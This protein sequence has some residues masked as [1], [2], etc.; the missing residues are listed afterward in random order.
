M[1]KKTKIKNKSLKPIDID[2]H[3]KYR[4]PGCGIDHWASFKEASTRHFIIVCDCSEVFSVKRI[5]N[6]EI[7]FAKKK[8]KEQEIQKTEPEKKEVV[9][10]IK[11]SV[12]IPDETLNK[13]IK[14]LV[15]LGFMKDEA[16][17]MLKETDASD[18]T[19]NIALLVKKSIAK[20]G[21]LNG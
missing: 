13:S 6:I 3:F 8:I 12:E 1:L 7:V 15:A 20:I 14:M 19:E 9:K 2:G 21:G 10:E 11:Q 16:E 5:S 18:P 4:C 17:S